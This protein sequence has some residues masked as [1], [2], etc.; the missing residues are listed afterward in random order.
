M[1]SLLQRLAFSAKDEYD[2]LF[3]KRIINLYVKLIVIGV[4]LWLFVDK[5]WSYK[6]MMLVFA[7]II[8]ETINFSL[9]PEHH[10]KSKSNDFYRKKKS[11]FSEVAIFH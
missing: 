6:M 5:E 1:K 11:I 9:F 3:R 2:F 4:I 8:Y 10:Y 7:G